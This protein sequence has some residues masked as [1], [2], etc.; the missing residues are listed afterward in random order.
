MPRAFREAVA[1]D[2][3]FLSAF[4]ACDPL[5]AFATNG[6]IVAALRNDVDAVEGV[7]PARRY[8]ENEG[9]NIQ[10]RGMRI[11]S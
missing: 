5:M 3:R 9:P 8:P 7:P 1:D 10:A 6:L 11:D 2:F 4:T